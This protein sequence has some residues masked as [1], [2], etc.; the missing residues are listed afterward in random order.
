MPARIRPDKPIPSIENESASQSHETLHED[1]T[2]S[3]LPA[4]IFIN[5]GVLVGFWF[6][7]A[8]G[9]GGRPVYCLINR[10]F[11]YAYLEGRTFF[12]VRWIDFDPFHVFGD[13]MGDDTED[14][15]C[16]SPEEVRVW[17]QTMWLSW[18][19][20]G[21]WHMTAEEDESI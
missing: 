1:E 2:G 16:M 10:D 17:V 6:T 21:N 7:D 14:N 9:R 4:P 13:W 11:E 5:E 19:Y 8:T 15:D 18:N 12:L 20:A 3:E